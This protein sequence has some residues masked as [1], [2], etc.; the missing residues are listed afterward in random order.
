LP[1]SL[2][3]V[4]KFFSRLNIRDRDTGTFI[5]F[6]LRPQ[7]REVFHLAEQH[8]ARRRRLFIIFL[9]ARR[10]GIS[11]IATG[12]GQAHC[13]AHPGSMARCIAQNAKVASANFA[14]ACSFFKDCRGLYPGAPK[15]TKSILTWPHS[16]GPDSTF[17]HHTAATVHGQRGLTSSF[18][19]LTEAAFYPYE[20][21]FTSLLNTLS[22]DPN[23]I[24][25]VETTANGLEGPGEAYYQYWEGAMA[26]ENEFLPIFL[27]WWDDPAYRLH[28]ELALDAPRDEYE[29]FLMNDVTHWR[30]G[31]KVKI[32]KSQIAWF[33]STLA[34]RCE[35]I[36]EK[37][38]AEFPSTC[39]EAFVATGNP[40]FT[41]EETQFAE[42]A[43]VRNPPWQGEC[44]LSADRKHGE[45]RKSLNGPL[46]LY[47]TPQP[48]H[49]YFAGVDSARGE[50]S[51]MAPGD[52][53]A[54]VVWN[55]ETGDLAGRYMSRV[56]PEELAN[57]SAALGY[58]FNGAMLVVELTGNLGYITMRELRDRLFYPSQYIW[59]GRDDRVDKSKQGVAL[60]F[61]T[62]DRYRRMMF[63]LF[64]TALH[65]KRVVP[66][67]RVFVDQ[68]K[69]AKL[70]MNWRW[71]VAVGH[72]DVL[73]FSPDTLVETQEGLKP[74]CEIRPS[75]FVRTHTG[76]LH[77]VRETITSDTSGLLVNVGITGNPEPIRATPNHPFYVCRYERNIRK[78]NV[79]LPTKRLSEPP[80]WKAAID[81]RLHDYVLFPKRKNLPRTDVPDDQL[82]VLGWFL[83]E[84]WTCP[85][86]RKI[87]Q[88]FML[89]FCLNSS[90]RLIAERICEVLIK[91]DPPSRSNNKP[92]RIIP[93]K[94]KNSIRIIYSSRYWH[95]LFSRLVGGLQPV[96]KIHSS[97]YNC[98][99]LMPMVGAFMSGE[100]SYIKS[101][102]TI[103]VSNTSRVLIH[104][105][106]QI[107]IDEGI[108]STIGFYS[109]PIWALNITSEFIERFVGISKFHSVEQ[110][111]RRQQF[112][113]T[114]EGF[115]LPVKT[116]SFSHH[117]G[118]VFNL[119]IEG[120]STYQAQGIAVHNCAGFLGWI[121]LE[122]NH[123]EP[124]RPRSP[125]N[126]LMT[127][128]EMENSGFTPTRGQMPEWT[129]D[130][131]VTGMGALLTTGNDH[132]R[133]LELYNKAK[134]KVNRLQW[135]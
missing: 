103:R 128:E 25:L 19:H 29:K 90:E 66:K 130:P 105:I 35:G 104:Q 135:I 87:N 63:A 64:R 98:S 67:D 7:Q 62:S 37:W 125:K 129:K 91:Y 39:L 24:C 58:Y 32:D 27:P 55:A 21:I 20:G 60:G 78:S 6:V 43:V 77:Q 111:I 81:L 48:K 31:K 119:S 95:E 57:V 17:E 96:R 132:L 110:L 28:E 84:G 120:D 11:T 68:M 30:T 131:T 121:A 108:W 4:E 3:H 94:G 53:A 76:E 112:V 109:Q 86:D 33:R 74:I 97:L 14:M 65:S 89:S 85:R 59:K 118:S 123:P 18:T 107:L 26:G 88:G 54:I 100:G 8:L 115:W 40:A 61:E 10:L 44:V 75:E 13:I 15:P 2:S 22:S 102:S 23:N 79:H 56:S 52:Y 51:T 127:R 116:L 93:V 34:T 72:D 50:E 36:I 73:C 69:K 106:R 9:K 126:V 70:E 114:D 133:K 101:V 113:E 42:N 80:A 46:V 71:T 82:W 16:D 99:G 5:P 117:S 45:L 134:Q 12:L 92:P 122:Q 47:E 83:A 49:H 124:C 1:L 41:M 38:R